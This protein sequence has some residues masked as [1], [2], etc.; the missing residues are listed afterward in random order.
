MLRAVSGFVSWCWS[1]LTGSH[2]IA[3]SPES[4][5]DMSPVPSVRRRRSGVFRVWTLRE[6]RLIASRWT[7]EHKR[8]VG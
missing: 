5:S 8:P 3:G 4:L 1:R 2:A 7:K 6:A